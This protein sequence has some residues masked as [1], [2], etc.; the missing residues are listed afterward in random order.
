[1]AM[2]KKSQSTLSE[3]T[4]RATLY[5]IG[6]AVI[7]TDKRSKVTLMN[8]VAE[9]LTGWKEGEARG[10]ALSTVFRIVN[11]E[12]RKKV[13]SPVERVLREGIVVGLANHTILISRNG[14]EIPIADAG[15]PVKDESGTVVGVVLVF[16]DQTAEREAQRAIQDAREFAESIIATVREPLLVLDEQLEVVA[17]N[18]SFYNVFKVKPE[19]T[20]GKTV[21]RLGNKQWNIPALWKLIEDILPSNSHFDDY[22]V[23]HDFEHIGRRTMLL[24]ARR[25]FR[26]VNR[27]KLILLA[28]ED[29]TERKRAE[30][31]LKESEERFRRISELTSDYAYAFRV[32]EDNRLVRE[33]VTDSFTRISGYTPQEVDERGGWPSLIHPDDMPIALAR[34]TRLFSGEDDVS[35]FRIVRKDGQSRWVRDHGHPVWDDKQQR[36]VRIY[37]AAQDITEQKKAEQAI[38]EREEWF[39][40][41]ADTTSTAIFIYQGERFVYVNK[42]TEELSGYTNHELLSLRFWDVVHPD[43]QNLIRERGLARQ[44]GE[45]VPNRYEFTIVRKDGAVRWIDFTAGK[46]DWR[47]EPAAIGTAIDITERKLVEQALRENEQRYRSI[48]ENINQAYYEADR[49]AAFTY[50]NPGIVIISGY[51]AE[52]LLGTISFRL[53]ADEDRP[54]VTAQY[55]QWLKEKRTDMMMEFRVQTKSGRIFWV[56]QVTHFEFDEQGNFVKATNVL[57]DIDERKRA[58]QEVLQSRQR[59]ERFFLQ[60]LTGDYISTPEGQLLACNPAFVRIFGFASEQEALNTNVTTLFRTPEDRQRLLSLLQRERKLEYYEMQMRK[61]DGSPLHIVANIIGRFDEHDRLVE[62]QGYLFDDTKRQQLEEQLRHTQKLE[63]LGTLASGI[64]HDFN[65]ILG[66]ILGH[67]TLLERIQT[68]PV[69]FSQ[70]L[71]AIQKATQRGASLVKQLLTFA[72]K[73]ETILESVNVNEVINEITKLLTQTLP[74]TIVVETHL[75]SDLPSIIADATQIHQVILNLCVNARD[76]MPRGG[77]LT[78]ATIVADGAL[79]NSRY[80]TA[81]ARNYVCITVADT[82]I[83]MDETTKER[84]FEPFFTTKG[85][86]KGTGLGLSLVYSIVQNHNGFVDVASEL[87]KGTTFTI[88]LPVEENKIV[89]FQVA[90]NEAEHSPGGTETIL[91]IED[92]EMLQEIGKTILASKG[93]TVLTAHDGEEGLTVY[94]RHREEIAAVISDLGLPKLGGDEVFR[95]IRTMN[96]TAKFILASGFIDPHLK[97][98]LYKLGVQFFIQKPYQLQEVLQVIREA[99]DKET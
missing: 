35:E 45:A 9:K 41:L 54:M 99:L 62:L 85:V 10:K 91:L 98:E 80:P 63:S 18:R 7:A 83:G 27:S 24:N 52:E 30:E 97:S 51:S 72:R 36:V 90:R 58:E 87:G 21:Y 57:R 74:K 13:E 68:D 3:S 93:Y 25:L 69:K 47:G 67:S 77:M 40:R 66:I 60:D 61:R 20:I 14:K 16:R 95:Q 44:R 33:W 5:S 55:K 29:I 8:P 65:N 32:E 48:V 15:A 28:I 92:E 1:M 49:L 46:I 43:F 78:I 23:T 64:A 6:D 73:T 19:E 71:E 2:K 17:A 26:E 86:G 59:Y 96:P 79:I 81:T 75:A 39:R 53:I 89:D 88:Y 42:A 76:A 84:I 56:E 31:A 4:L 94:R 82:G 38:R 70:S 34:A 37:G 11:E 12:T 22:E 50:C